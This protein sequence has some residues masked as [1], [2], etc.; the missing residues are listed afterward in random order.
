MN[1]AFFRAW[2]VPAYGATFAT[3]ESWG[4]GGTELQLLLQA[5]ALRRLGNS[6]TVFGASRTPRCEEGVTFLPSVSEGTHQDAVVACGYEV[7]FTNAATRL[8]QLRA[9]FPRAT[10]VQMCQN[11]PNL[12][13][14]RE[15]DLFAM[16]G[17]G[18][19]AAWS[20][21]EPA[22]RHRFLMVPNVVPWATVYEDVYAAEVSGASEHVVTWVGGYG[23]Q[24]L[25]RW[26]RAMA[27]V[28]RTDQNLRWVLCGPSYQALTGGLPAELQRLGLPQDRLTFM[29]LPLP[30]LAK[31]IMRSKVV[32]TSL[33]GEDGPVS[34]LD[35]QALGVPVACADDLVAKFSTA[36]GAG[37][38]CRSVADCSRALTMV[39]NDAPMRAAMGRAGQRYVLGRFTEA[40]QEQALVDLIEL[41]AARRRGHLPAA[42]PRQRS[43]NR[44]Y[45][46]EFLLERA[47]VKVVKLRA[48]PARRRRVAL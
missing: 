4:V 16:V 5:R 34:Y 19:H 37:I 43:S 39:L 10:I 40:Q 12:R 36:E 31:Q 46:P 7:V 22:L 8:P 26:G 48:L 24:G 41:V 17:P 42:L 28:M 6:V 2:E 35:P 20:Y 29:N 30:E 18:Q 47:A 3:L 11:G 33:G 38:R 1:V 14:H 32:L 21:R 23:K 9:L 25:R 27:G 44:K 15:I 45:P 13:G